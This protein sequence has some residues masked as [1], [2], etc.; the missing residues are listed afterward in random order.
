MR[1]A[2]GGLYSLRPLEAIERFYAALTLALSPRE[3]VLRKTS[4]ATKS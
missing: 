3:R 2:G 1:V 4:Y